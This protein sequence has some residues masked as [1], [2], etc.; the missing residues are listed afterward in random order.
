MSLKTL[1]LNIVNVVQA[2]ATD[3]TSEN[4]SNEIPGNASSNAIKS[5]NKTDRF[6]VVRRWQSLGVSLDWGKEEGRHSLHRVSGHY[7]RLEYPL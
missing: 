7:R 2:H 4:H 3:A 6:H 5:R 1:C